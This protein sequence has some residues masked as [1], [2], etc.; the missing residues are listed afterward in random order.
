VA[1]GVASGQV[2]GT[3]TLFIDG[4]LHEESCDAAIPH[5]GAR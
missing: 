4:V 2:A 5:P 1:S 3:L